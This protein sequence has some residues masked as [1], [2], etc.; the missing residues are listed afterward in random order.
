MQ[1]AEQ[2]NPK[3]NR[4]DFLAFIPQT[5]EEE[6]ILEAMNNGVWENQVFALLDKDT[7]EVLFDFQFSK[8]EQNGT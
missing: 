2:R 7:D 3:T 1:V 4:L 6:R 8:G 5:F